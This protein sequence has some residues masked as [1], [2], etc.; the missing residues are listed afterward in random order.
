MNTDAFIIN[1]LISQQQQQ[2]QQQHE[3]SSC[4]DCAVENGNSNELNHSTSL[5]DLYNMYKNLTTLPS[6]PFEFGQSKEELVDLFDFNANLG[7]LTFIL[8]G[9]MNQKNIQRINFFFYL[10]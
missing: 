3:G 9:Y 2:Q 10:N 6:R 7:N 1:F 5:T 8:F 4:F